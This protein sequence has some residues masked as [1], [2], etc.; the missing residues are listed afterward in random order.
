MYTLY[1]TSTSTKHK[2]E[3]KVLYLHFHQSC[4]VSKRDV[5]VWSDLLLK[6]V[7]GECVFNAA[8]EVNRRWRSIRQRIH[9]HTPTFCPISVRA[10]AA[11]WI[12]LVC[13]SLLII[14]WTHQV[15]GETFYR[16]ID[17]VC[18]LHTLRSTQAF[19]E[20]LSKCFSRIYPTSWSP[21]PL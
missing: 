17:I 19:L 2:L 5:G 14:V 15:V 12:K 20:A 13:W 1:P 11:N 9:L 10:A 7:P 21:P 6:A 18:Q 4:L 8:P 3:A 16:H